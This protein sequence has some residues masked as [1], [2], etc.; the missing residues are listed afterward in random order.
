MYH[1]LN[2]NETVEMDITFTEELLNKMQNLLKTEK[3]KK[4]FLK[5]YDTLKDARICDVDQYEDSI[6]VDQD[7]IKDAY[8]EIGDYSDN[9]DSTELY[10]DFYNKN[11]N[12]INILSDIIYDLDKYIYNLTDKHLSNEKLLDIR[13]KL[14]DI[15]KELN[16]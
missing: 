9:E 11:K 6:E 13:E 4:A 1:T 10:I 3:E 14:N 12:T 16:V 8:H 5:I 2:I 15:T 7:N